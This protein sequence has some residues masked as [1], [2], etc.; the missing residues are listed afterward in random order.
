MPITFPTNTRSIINEI[1]DVIGRDVICYTEVRQLCPVCSIDPV[2]DESTDPF[3]STCSGIG[4]L[5]SYS[6]NTINAHI[7]WAP[8]EMLAWTAGGQ[9]FDGDCRI[10]IEYTNNNLT[11]IDGV[12]HII[13]DGK[14]CIVRK[15]MPRGVQEINRLLVDLSLEE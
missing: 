11:V 1:R 12:D 13:V 14:K 3:C 7:T 10:Q 2:A 5:V 4:Y 15:K 8:S 6:G 9:Y